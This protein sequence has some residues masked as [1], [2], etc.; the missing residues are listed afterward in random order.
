MGIVAFD[1]SIGVAVFVGAIRRANEGVRR[2]YSG[3]KYMHPERKVG[4]AVQLPAGAA[5]RAIG[6]G[7][8]CGNRAEQAG[9][10]G[11]AAPG[12]LPG[13]DRKA[14]AAQVLNDSGRVHQ[15][16]DY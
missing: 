13:A 7:A 4:N 1:A 8:V 16:V 3:A 6:E 14:Q 10:A 15:I 5:Y 12:G 11:K 9:A 2:P